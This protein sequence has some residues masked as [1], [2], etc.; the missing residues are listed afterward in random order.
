MGHSE[1]SAISCRRLQATKT[2]SPSITLERRAVPTGYQRG[3]ANNLFSSALMNLSNRTIEAKQS[4]D[5][6]EEDVEQKLHNRV[7]FD[8]TCRRLNAVWRANIGCSRRVNESSFL[9][10]SRL[11]DAGSV[12]RMLQLITQRSRTLER[13]EKWI[14][15]QF[16]WS[17]FGRCCRG[18]LSFCQI[19]RD[20]YFLENIQMAFLCPRDVLR[21]R[22]FGSGWKNNKSRKSLSMHRA[23]ICISSLQLTD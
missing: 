6:A 15:R 12:S 5:C 20:F 18:C 16:S 23:G 14:C 8:A 9:R 22:Q 4:R 21:I 11:A 19:I 7:G 1:C 3:A 2:S 17:T 10:N 13:E